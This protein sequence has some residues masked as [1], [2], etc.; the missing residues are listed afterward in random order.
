[1]QFDSYMLFRDKGLV[2]RVTESDL[3]DLKSIKEDIY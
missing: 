2:L 3:R 1:M